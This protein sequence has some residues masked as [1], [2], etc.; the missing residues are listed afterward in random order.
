M[1]ILLLQA[2]FNFFVAGLYEVG[3][4]SVFS[5]DPVGNDVNASDVTFFIPNSADALNAF[6]D[7]T[8]NMSSKVDVLDILRYH[9]VT[10]DLVYSTMFQDGMQLKTATGAN[11]TISKQNGDIFV[12]QAKI[13]TPDFLVSNGVV[14]VIDG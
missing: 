2:N 3:I 5:Y 4:T 14:H 7:I 9:I 8:S 10:N 1:G 12:N 6:T 13:I 11:I